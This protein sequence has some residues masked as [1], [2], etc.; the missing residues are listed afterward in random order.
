[1]WNSIDLL[2]SCQILSSK[3]SRFLTLSDN[4]PKE[5]SQKY[6]KRRKKEK[7]GKNKSEHIER[8]RELTWL[9]TPV[10]LMNDYYRVIQQCYPCFKTRKDSTDYAGFDTLVHIRQYLSTFC[11]LFLNQVFQKFTEAVNVHKRFFAATKKITVKKYPSVHCIVLHNN[12]DCRKVGPF[13]VMHGTKM[14]FYS[15]LAIALSP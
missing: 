3:F 6:W 2:S 8:N 4:F 10:I 5:K 12:T 14:Y 1:M 9:M 11:Q 15:Y 7:K 13:L